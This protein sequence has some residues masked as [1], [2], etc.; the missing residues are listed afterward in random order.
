MYIS[1]QALDIFYDTIMEEI[2]WENLLKKKW[3][4]KWKWEFGEIEAVQVVQTCRESGA[5]YDNTPEDGDPM[6]AARVRGAPEAMERLLADI[7]T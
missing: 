3:K 5:D 2:S 4:W 7:Q 1:A 6:S